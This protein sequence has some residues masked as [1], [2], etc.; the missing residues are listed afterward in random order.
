M[1]AVNITKSLLDILIRLSEG[2]KADSE[3]PSEFYEYK[4]ELYFDFTLC[5]CMYVCM[6]LV[7][8]LYI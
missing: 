2:D 4:R 7:S 8:G 5:V 6:Y 1:V 3:V